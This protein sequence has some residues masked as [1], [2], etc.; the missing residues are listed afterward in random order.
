LKMKKKEIEDQIPDVHV[1]FSFLL[2]GVQLLYNCENPATL[3]ICSTQKKRWYRCNKVLENNLYV[4][5]L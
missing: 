5:K 3:V 2:F 4:V 1:F